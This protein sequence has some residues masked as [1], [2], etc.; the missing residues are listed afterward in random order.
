MTMNPVRDPRRKRLE[1]RVAIPRASNGV[2]RTTR[3]LV[4]ATVG[5]P[6]QPFDRFVRWMD[7]QV[8]ARMKKSEVL[9]QVGTSKVRPTHCQWIDFIPMDGF[10]EMVGR[11]QVVVCHGGQGSIL[12]CLQSGKRPII[13]PRLQKFDEHINDHQLE[14]VEEFSKRKLI[15][16]VY[17]ER[18]LHPQVLNRL[19]DRRGYTY[20]PHNKL[21][22]NLVGRILS[23]IEK[24]S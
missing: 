5:N 8:G 21:M 14:I 19:R 7:E 22:L 9:I 11:A 13:I 18:D 20:K 3:P 23:D 2:K 16:A 1:P 6:T 15:D 10:V 17:E 4:F 24:R 12:T